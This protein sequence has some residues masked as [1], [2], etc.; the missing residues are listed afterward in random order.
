MAKTLTKKQREIIANT[1]RAFLVVLVTVL[2]LFPLFVMIVR[3]LMSYD[4]LFYEP[5]LLPAKLEFSNYYYEPLLE[6]FLLW[7]SNTLTIVVCN[8]IGTIGSAFLC[9]YGFAKVRFKF[10]SVIFGITMASTMLPSITL[11]IPLYRLYYEWGWLDNSL[12]P[13]IIPAFFGGGALNIFLIMQFIKGIPNST[14]ESARIDSASE[15]RCLFSIVVPACL[16]IAA[17]ISVNT[18]LGVW[19]DYS[20]A[21]IYL[22]ETPEKWTLSLG[23]YMEAIGNDNQPDSFTQN[24][25]MAMGVLMCIP[26]LLVFGCSQSLLI[27]GVSISGMKA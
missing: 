23:F 8:I 14:L 26:P 21:L 4:E 3:S 6:S 27:E 12:K 22:S 10:K 16:P 5:K 1:T 7:G 25:Q 17:L 15:L 13:L 11:R 19:N 9:A 20:S 24:R 18:F 2:L